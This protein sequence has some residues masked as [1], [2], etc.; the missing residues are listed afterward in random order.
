MRVKTKGDDTGVKDEGRLINTS[1][2]MTLQ[3]LAGG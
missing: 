2:I 1:T 3:T